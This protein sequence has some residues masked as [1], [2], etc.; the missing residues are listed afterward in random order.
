MQRK[1][2]SCGHLSWTQ[3]PQSLLLVAPGAEMLELYAPPPLLTPAL[4][5]FQPWGNAIFFFH[6]KLT[7]SIFDSSGKSMNTEY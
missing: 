2:G 3:A 5:G 7:G 1:T 6:K 4:W